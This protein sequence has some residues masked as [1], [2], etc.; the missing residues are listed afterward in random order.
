MSDD[1]LQIACPACHVLNRVP[2]SRLDERPNCGRCREPLFAA[3][4]FAL[5][6]EHFD[7]HAL[8][9]DLPLLVDFWAPWCGPCLQMAPAFAASAAQ[10]EPWMHLVKVDTQAQPQLGAQFGIRSIP[11]LV[12]LQRGEEIARQSGAMP[13]QAIIQFA[14]NALIRHLGEG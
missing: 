5:D 8:R 7:S 11:T 9:A 1:L 10:L 13:A 3:V 12:L 6:A 4:P 14:R 2:Q